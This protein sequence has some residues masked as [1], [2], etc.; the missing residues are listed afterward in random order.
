LLSNGTNQV[1]LVLL[2]VVDGADSLRHDAS[3]EAIY[4]APVAGEDV[5]RVVYTTL[6]QVGR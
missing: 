4:L 6:V 2:G 1:A 5:L 3:V